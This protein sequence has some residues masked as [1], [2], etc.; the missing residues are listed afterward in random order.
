MYL[1]ITGT[2]QHF[3]RLVINEYQNN[4][5]LFHKG[6]Y[7]NIRIEQQNEKNELGII[8]ERC[9]QQDYKVFLFG[10]NP[11]KHGHTEGDAAAHPSGV[12]GF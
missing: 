3:G 4:I 8:L 12:A 9:A 6:G 7:I 1:V 2:S 11:D 5:R 10:F